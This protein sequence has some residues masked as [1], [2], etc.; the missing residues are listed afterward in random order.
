MIN[1]HYKEI[2][3]LIRK[4]KYVDYYFP[5]LYGF[6]PYVGCEHGCVYCDGRCEKYY[7]EGIFD[8]D[9]TIRKNMID[10]LK[11]EMPKK[12]EKGAIL[13]GSGV[14]DPYQPVEA[15]EGLMRE[16]LEVIESYGFPVII[17]TKSHLLLR[18][19]DLLKRIN[20]KAK[21]TVMVSLTFTNDEERKRIEPFASSVEERLRILKEC[22]KAGLSTGLLAMPLLPYITETKENITN[23]L[24][25]AKEVDVDFVMASGLTLRAG[26]QKEGYF[27]LIEE[28]YP[29]LLDSY[30][31]IYSDNKASGAPKWN[32]PDNQYSVLN[33]QMEKYCFSPFLPFEV[34]RQQLPLYRSIMILL[35]V[36]NTLYKRKGISTERLKNSS[37]KYSNWINEKITYYNR[38]RNLK[39]EDL[40]EEVFDMMESGRINEIIENAKLSHFL[41]KIVCED[42]TLDYF[43]LKLK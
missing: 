26:I 28:Y 3:T 7:V 13:I 4:K 9:I 16:A 19:I 17:L 15:E 1:K 41:F 30:K 10:L 21:S 42:K 18:D 20:Q 8:K 32:Y 31:Y 25:E 2:K 33:E 11:E 43:D 29:E 24:K 22:K 5:G 12:R 36:M 39:Y 35:S 14:S 27:K 37:K 23:L 38:R 40:E 6:S 34:V